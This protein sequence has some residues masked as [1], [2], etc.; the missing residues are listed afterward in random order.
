MGKLK[1]LL[2]NLEKNVCR[3]L[4]PV[5]LLRPAKAFKSYLQP[6]DEEVTMKRSYFCRIYRI[7]GICVKSYIELKG[8]QLQSQ[9]LVFSYF[10]PKEGKMILKQMGL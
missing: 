6:V 8:T 1:S 10:L 5:K 4:Q 2:R 7:R 9:I 3:F